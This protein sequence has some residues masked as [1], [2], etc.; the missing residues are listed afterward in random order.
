MTL[1]EI[2]PLLVAA[3]IGL[4]T[5]SLVRS[6][7]ERSG[8]ETVRIPVRYESKRTSRLIEVRRL[9]D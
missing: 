4:A 6:N 2:R 9:V 3:L 5:L 8:S 1:E 7:L